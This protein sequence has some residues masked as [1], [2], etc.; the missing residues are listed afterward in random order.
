MGVTYRASIGLVKKQAW[1][2]VFCSSSGGKGKGGVKAMGFLDRLEEGGKH[3]EGQPRWT[4]HPVTSAHLLT[5]AF[6]H[7]FCGIR[8]PFSS[9]EPEAGFV[10]VYITRDSVMRREEVSTT[11][12][13]SSL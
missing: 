3:S 4:Q 7:N 5:L 8:V 13:V 9:Y 1:R 11:A 12:A 10:R 6:T 2:I